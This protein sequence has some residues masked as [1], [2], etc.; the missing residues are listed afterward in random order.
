MATCRRPLAGE[1]SACVSGLRRVEPS[2]WPERDAQ[3][4][5][6]SATPRQRVLAAL[7]LSG[8][9]LSGADWR[10]KHSVGTV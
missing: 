1:W 7:Q 10:P 5:R 8:A 2:L 3:L 6:R 9:L 4:H